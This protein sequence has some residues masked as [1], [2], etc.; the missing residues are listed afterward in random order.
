MSWGRE[1]WVSRLL[2]RPKKP[3]PGPGSSQ[4]HE[5]GDEPAV[6]AG[7]SPPPTGGPL[8]PSPALPGAWPRGK[9]VADIYEVVRELGRGGMGVVYLL[10]ERT[11]ERPAAAK[12]AQA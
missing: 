11:T 7:A 6:R 4:Q 10:E 3:S 5:R 1:S 9:V 8:T 12:V 2:R